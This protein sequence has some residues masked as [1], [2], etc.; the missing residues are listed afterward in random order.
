MRVASLLSR[1]IRAAV[2]AAEAGDAAGLVAALEE[3][4]RP[5]VDRDLA[6]V[7]LSRLPL[8]GMPTATHARS[9]PP[10]GPRARSKQGHIMRFWA[11]QASLRGAFSEEQR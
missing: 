1:M 7:A 10:S 6:T 4:P 11:R 2:G 5:I 8:A 3:C 9:P